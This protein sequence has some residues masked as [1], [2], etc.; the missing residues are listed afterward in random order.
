MSDIKNLEEFKALIERYESI[1]LEEIKGAFDIHLPFYV[2]KN[3]TGFGSEYTCSLCTAIGKVPSVDS[4]YSCGPCVYW[5]SAYRNYG[6]CEGENMESFDK[7]S[8][9]KTPEDLFSAYRE[10]AK[11]MRSLLTKYKL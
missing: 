8:D 3:L 11:H 10:R 1:T 6:C 5:V 7:I 2:R 4:F 9:A